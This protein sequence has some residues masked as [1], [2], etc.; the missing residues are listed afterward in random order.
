MEKNKFVALT[1]GPIYKTLKNARK[2]RELWGTSY[3]F[4]Y[5][6]KQIIK[7]I[8]KT[9]A[10]IILPFSDIIEIDGKKVD[11]LN[12]KYAAGLFPDQ[13]IVKENDNC[14]F[15][16]VKTIVDAVEKG[17]INKITKHLDANLKD[18]EKG[19]SVSYLSN[20]F[21]FYMIQREF[22]DS[23]LITDIVGKLFENLNSLE[24]QDKFIESEESNFIA[25]FLT[26]SSFKKGQHSFLIQDA[27]KIGEKEEVRFQ[28]IIEISAKEL[29]DKLSVE[30]KKQF[31]NKIGK[32]EKSDE[33]SLIK[34]LKENDN[35]K[36]LFKTHHKYIAIVHIDGDNF[37]KINKNLDDDFFKKF[38]DSLVKYSLRLHKKIDDYG[39]LPVY[40]GG[41]DALFFAPL[42]NGEID[43]FTLIDN[44]D[45]I[46]KDEFK[47]IIKHEQDK[48]DKGKKGI[49]PSLSVGISL[50]Y[51]KF[52]MQ[53]T[54]E[55]SR[56]LLDDVA[57]K[58]PGKN[59]IA[60][61]VLK[62]SGQYFGTVFNKNSKTY[63]C[64]EKITASNMED[65]NFL[66]SIPQRILANEE[67]MISIGNNEGK[68][69]NYIENNY[70]ENIHK[71]EP[72]S[73]FLENFGELIVAAFNEYGLVAKEANNGQCENDGKV[74]YE[75]INVIYSTLR[76]VKFL[77]R[78]DNE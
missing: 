49:I 72:Y 14:T 70:N 15:E 50:S 8:K 32:A 37:G 29:I 75:A 63:K 9:K 24:L 19:E 59:A 66:N 51:Y 65:E 71:T 3:L 53:E 25:N 35:T 21:K 61:K 36:G 12:D 43:I 31:E 22:D 55:S 58:Y 52:P 40:I 1:I 11:I 26:Q 41:D 44:I 13:L 74:Y 39:G 62:H 68:V 23:T 76:M 28:S 54:L 48:I 6:M 60:F 4:S 42:R 77:N 67:V 17:I 18:E 2:T 57:K 73:S 69:K 20:F 45:D 7:E 38:S 5:M 78:N 47:D 30:E 46:F 27:M 56:I 33:E 34:Y 10:E 16:K 64:F